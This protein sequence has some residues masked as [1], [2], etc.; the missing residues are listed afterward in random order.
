LATARERKQLGTKLL[1]LIS[2]SRGSF[3]THQE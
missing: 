3:G 2:V 1:R